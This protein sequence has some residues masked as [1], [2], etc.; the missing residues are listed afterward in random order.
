M[1]TRRSSR[2][3]N[4][5][6]TATAARPRQRR[7]QPAVSEEQFDDEPVQE[8][9]PPPR[10][11]RSEQQQEEIVEDAAEEKSLVPGDFGFA[12]EGD[13]GTALAVRE[14]VTAK[15]SVP[16][17]AEEYKS[18]TRVRFPANRQTQWQFPVQGEPGEYEGADVI[19]G[20]I[21]AVSYPRNLNVEKYD[22][23]NPARPL[24]SSRDGITGYADMSQAD[25]AAE[26]GLGAEQ[27]CGRSHCIYATFNGH[28]GFRCMPRMALW[29]MEQG[30]E[31]PIQVP[32]PTTYMKYFNKYK[33]E[34]GGLG[35]LHQV[36]TVISTDD[37]EDDEGNHHPM[38][39]VS[40]DA[41]AFDDDALERLTEIKTE[42]L[43]E[44][45]NEGVL[46][47]LQWET[48]AAKAP[49]RAAW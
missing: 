28:E 13:Q 14:P 31:D 17:G 41:P 29:V 45:Q 10:R 32:I 25:R 11:S 8:E 30:S 15:M 49:R 27:A 38:F 34:M 20:V 16:E 19:E 33:R 7:Q 39:D 40:A 22:P 42:I 21:M 35:N 3:E 37:Y 1:A 2:S 5:G 9:A 24:C 48:S 43:E 47:D 6:G 46:P 36:V 4:G 44:L 18:Y 23:K 12:S 26:F